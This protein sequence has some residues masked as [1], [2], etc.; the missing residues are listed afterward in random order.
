MNHPV[1]HE[2]E[3]S[4]I[5]DFPGNGESEA[6]L[7]GIE[8]EM[9]G[10]VLAFHGQLGDLL[11][12]LPGYKG[13]R[14]RLFLSGLPLAAGLLGQAA[15]GDP[16][17]PRAPP[18]PV[19]TANLTPGPAPEPHMHAGCTFYVRRGHCLCAQGAMSMCAVCTAYVHRKQCL[20]A[21][22]CTV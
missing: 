7:P 1:N 17:P 12:Q 13:V 9:A 15:L 11:A 5:L 8:K 14:V 19:S 6:D 16:A 3:D 22:E 20:C 4:H 21:Q 2:T 18:P 10:D